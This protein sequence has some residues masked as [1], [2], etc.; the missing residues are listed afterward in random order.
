MTLEEF[1]KLADIWGGDIGRWP[2][3]ARPSGNELARTDR[4][5]AI[6][7]EA[8]A[9]DRMLAERPTVSDE[10]ARGVAHAVVLALA[11]Q[12]GQL[13]RANWGRRLIPWLVPA[14]LICSGLAGSALAMMLSPHRI[15]EQDVLRMVLECGS[16]AA[17]LTCQ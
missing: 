4:G 10:R 14:S 7:R 16:F 11:A 9:L 6:L 17:R 5:G 13:S 1:Q 2:D 15:S 3:N 12:S 8:A